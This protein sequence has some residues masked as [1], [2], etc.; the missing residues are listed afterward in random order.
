MPNF[1]EEDNEQSYKDSNNEDIF[2]KQMSQLILKWQAVHCVS[3]KC[4]MSLFHLISMILSALNAIIKSDILY[5][6]IKII[7]QT[8]YSAR[9]ISGADRNDF[10]QFV[11]CTECCSTYKKDESITR[12]IGISLLNIFWLLMPSVSIFVNQLLLE[13][14]RLFAH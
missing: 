1:F 2:V 12:R 8:L 14:L 5:D 3:D 4:I 9:K 11:V 7:P 10:E 13:S 6:I